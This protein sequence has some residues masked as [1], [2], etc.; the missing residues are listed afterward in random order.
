MDMVEL[1]RFGPWIC[2]VCMQNKQKML[3]CFVLGLSLAGGGYNVK[4]GSPVVELVVV[5][6]CFSFK[7]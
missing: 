7:M 5:Q 6:A 2:V 1:C 3:F 4:A